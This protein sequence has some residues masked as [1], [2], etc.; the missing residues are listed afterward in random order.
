[1][2]K[3]KKVKTNRKNRFLENIGSFNLS[4][5]SVALAFVGQYVIYDNG[6]LIPGLILLFTA[7]VLFIMSSVVSKVREGAPEEKLDKR[8]EL[9]FF[10]LILAITVFYRVY[11]IDKLPSGCYRDEGQNGNEAINIMNGNVIDGTSLPVYIERWTQ[12]AAMY[13]YFIAASFKFF[14]ID[15]L[16]IRLVSVVF[17]ILCVPAFYFVIRNFFGPRMAIVSGLLLAVMRWHVNFSRMGFLGILTV[18]L[19]ILIMYFAYRCYKERKM[20]DFILLGITLALSLYT[21]LASRLIPAGLALFMAYLVF[22]DLSFYK[23]HWKK[24]LIAFA[25]FLITAAPMILYAVQNPSNFMSRSSTVSIFNKEML[26]Q[27][28]GRYVQKDGTPKAW[29]ELYIESVGQT[30]L[31]FNFKGDGNPRHN[32]GATPMLDFVTGIFFFLGFF[33][34][35]WHWRKPL[36]F[37]MLALFATM[38]QAGLFSTDPPHAYRTIA[39]IPIVL[40]FVTAA[41]SYLYG[42]VMANFGKKANIALIAAASA[43]VLFAGYQNY[44]QYFNKFYNNPGSWAEFSVDEYE[45]GKYVHNLGDDWV[46]IVEGSWIN[47]YTFIFATY[48]YKNFVDFNPSE[49]I[50]IKTKVIKNFTYVLDDSYLPLLPVLKKMYPNSKYGDVRHKFFKDNIMYFTLEV[51]YSDV[52]KQQDAPKKNGLLGSYYRDKITKDTDKKSTEEAV[53]LSNH[54]QGQPAKTVLDPFILFN[55]TL[56]PLMGPFSVKW[57]GRIRIDEAGVYEFT[58]KSNDYS[59][60]SIGGKTVLRNPGGGGGLNPVTAKISLQKGYHNILLRYYESV[61]YSKMQFWWRAPGQAEA[62]VVPS[63]VLFP[64]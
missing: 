9:V 27:I 21:Y 25:A 49:W 55:W 51:P 22:Y 44:N 35:L 20:S 58:T 17:G 43:A 53:K 62:E 59:D 2:A 7:A 56:D 13:M 61:Q 12:N 34:C 54:W 47:S 1:M 45:M 41:I 32:A 23:K 11:M 10:L 48:P 40:V 16:Q 60:L 4:M 28:G 52:K 14:G 31:M 38:L 33:Y 36:N 50:P 3:K 29:E 39:E 8:I 57:T 19:L 64:Q 30:F 63:E 6:K 37:M 24:M 15:V 42:T 5:V 46:A 18:F 26:S